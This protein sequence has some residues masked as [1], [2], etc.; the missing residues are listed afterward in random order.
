MSVNIEELSAVALCA[1]CLKI[2]A[3]GGHEV[4]DFDDNLPTLPKLLGSACDL[5]KYVRE[6]ILSDEVN[7]FLEAFGDSRLATETSHVKIWREIYPSEGYMIVELR[8]DLSCGN[9]S[10]HVLWCSLHAISGM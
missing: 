6:V 2:D 7:I 5:C 8:I 4:A 9:I 10:K 3:F 1:E